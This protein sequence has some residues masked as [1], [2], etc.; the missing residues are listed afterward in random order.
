M[1]VLDGYRFQAFCFLFPD[2]KI[3]IFPTFFPALLILFLSAPLFLLSFQ[4]FYPPPSPQPRIVLHNLLPSFFPMADNTEPQNCIKR[5]KTARACDQCRSGRSRCDIETPHASKREGNNCARC[6]R[7]KLECTFMLPI[8]ETRGRR[9]TAQ[10][11]GL[12]PHT[13]HS[14]STESG[15]FATLS[16]VDPCPDPTERFKAFLVKYLP[17]ITPKDLSHDSPILLGL[18]ARLLTVLCSESSTDPAVDELRTPLEAYM[19]TK[20]P[21]KNP[22]LQNVQAL[23]LLALLVDEKSYGLKFTTAVRMACSLGWNLQPG[24]AEEGSGSAYERNLWWALV[25]QDIWLYLYS[26]LPMLINY[27]DFAVPRLAETA[28]PIFAHLLTLSEIL[29]SIIRPTSLAES[30]PHLAPTPYQALQVWESSLPRIET[31]INTPT[32]P[33]VTVSEKFMS[34]ESVVQLLHTTILALLILDNSNEVVNTNPEVRLSRVLGLHVEFPNVF[35]R[36]GVLGRCAAICALAMVRLGRGVEL[37][38]WKRVVGE[39]VWRKVVE[40]EQSGG[41]WKVVWE[42][43]E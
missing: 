26:G 24:D 6:E 37:E 9:A 43:C 27:K 34:P 42:I 1:V 14:P 3:T 17:I 11:Q 7:L 20:S 12:N 4:H 16:T 38:E 39:G 33:A 15:T 36:F 30:T 19:L 40:K 2:I 5:L 8:G 13:R 32:S 29:R 18:C 35:R 23:M 10:K 31:R 25:I 22:A 41:G 21:F 28:P